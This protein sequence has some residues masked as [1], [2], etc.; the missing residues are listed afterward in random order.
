MQWSLM[1]LHRTEPGLHS[2]SGTSILAMFDSLDQG[3]SSGNTWKTIYSSIH[4]F[5][6]IYTYN[7]Y[8]PVLKHLSAEASA[9]ASEILI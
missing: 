7:V 9:A 5:T 2:Y 1:E 3:S 4:S 6:F 8:S